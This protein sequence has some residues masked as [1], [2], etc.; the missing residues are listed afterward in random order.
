M[1]IDLNK[2]AFEFA[3]VK[4]SGRFRQRE[5]EGPLQLKPLILSVVNRLQ[6]V[7]MQLC[8]APAQVSRF[9]PPAFTAPPVHITVDFHAA[10]I[11]LGCQP[12]QLIPVTEETFFFPF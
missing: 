9:W 6:L 8:L 12:L 7:G 3:G 5:D 2:M 4:S 11:S 10:L 1:L